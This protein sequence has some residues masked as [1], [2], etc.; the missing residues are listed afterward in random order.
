MKSRRISRRFLGIFCLAL[1]AALPLAR[2]WGYHQ[3]GPDRVLLMNNDTNAWCQVSYQGYNDTNT[4]NETYWVHSTEEPSS[5]TRYLKTGITHTMYRN[6]GTPLWHLKECR[7]GSGAVANA[8]RNYITCSKTAESINTPGLYGTSM[9]VADIGSVI[10][11]DTTESHIYSP[12]YEE[13]IG[14]VYFDAVNAQTTEPVVIGLEIATE[15][16]EGVSLNSS[17]YGQ[18]IWKPCPATFFTWKAGRSPVVTLIEENVTNMTLNITGGANALIYRIRAN[19]YEYLNGYRGPARFRIVRKEQATASGGDTAFVLV[20]NIVASY[21]PMTAKI[22]QYGT[23]D[24]TLT[25]ADVEGFV[26]SF[27]PALLSVSTT[28]IQMA[29]YFT[30]VTNSAEVVND[31]EE[32]FSLSNVR[33]ISRWRYLNQHIENWKTNEL[34]VSGSMAVSSPDLRLVSGVGDVEYYFAFEQNAP[35]YEPVD[36]TQP[37]RSGA[38]Y[39]RGWS[40]ELTNI[41]SRATYTAEDALPSG[42]TDWFTR[43]REGASDYAYISLVGEVTTNGAWGAN[44]HSVENN[45]R[46]KME[47]VSDHTWRYHYYIPTNAIGEHVRFHFEGVK[48]ATNDVPFVFNVTTNIWYANSTNVPYLPYTM[49]ASGSAEDAFDAEV[50]LDGSATHLQI[51]FND[52]KG[53]FAL[54]RG[55]YQNFNMWTDANDGYRGDYTS[56]TGVSDVK[57]RWD[58]AINDWSATK[59][60]NTLWREPFEVNEEDIGTGKDYEYYKLGAWKTPNGWSSE[61]SMYVPRYR[62]APYGLAL[63]L[64]GKGE[65]S[66]MLNTKDPAPNGIGTVDFAARVAQIPRFDGFC[67]DYFAGGMQNYA[68]SA[69]VTMSRLYDTQYNPLDISPANPSVSLIGYYQGTRNGCYEFR[70]TRSGDRQL[71]VALYRWKNEVANL[72]VENVITVVNSGTSLAPSTAQKALGVGGALN[73]APDSTSGATISGFNNLLVPMNNDDARLY[74]WTCMCLSLYSD[75]NGVHLNGYL[76]PNRNTSYLSADS[77]VKRVIAYRDEGSDLKKGGSPGIGSVGCQAG[78]ALV[79]T[80][81]FKDESTYMIRTKTDADKD[82]GQDS[83]YTDWDY[84]AENWKPYVLD[85]TTYDASGFTALI[86]TNQTVK[87]FYSKLGKEEGNWIDSGWETNITAFATNTFQFAPCV[88]PDYLVRL[89]TGPSDAE[90]VIDSVEVRSWR[91]S[92]TPNLSSKNGQYDAWAYTMASIETAADIEGAYDVQPAGTN[93]YAFI[94]NEP[95]VVSFTPKVDMVIDRALLVGGGGAGGWTLGGGGGGGGVLEY[96]WEDEPATVPAGTTIRITVGAGGDNFYKNNNDSGNWKA[97]GNGGL[98]RVDNIP[99]TGRGRLEAKGGGGD[100]GWNQRNAASGNATGGGA[101]QGNDNGYYSSRATGTSGQ[102]NSGGRAYGDRAGGGGGAD[103][104]EAGMGQDGNATDNKAGD[105]GA[106]RAS[107]ITGTVVYYGGGGGGGGGDG[108]KTPNSAQGGLGGIGGGGKGPPAKAALSDRNYMDGTDGL[109]GGG[110]GGSH[111]GAAG[112]NAGGRGGC[113]CVIL[114][115]RTAAKLC[116]LQPTKSYPADGPEYQNADYPMSIRSKWLDNGL[117]LFSFSYRDA[118]SNAVLRLQ[119]STNLVD[120]GVVYTRT[121]EPADSPNWTTLTNWSF[122]GVSPDKLKED[123][124]TYFLSLRAPH[125]GLMRL[126]MDPAVVTQALLQA[127]NRATRNLDF[128][129]ITVTRIFCYDEPELDARSWW[130]W[131]L[132]TEGWNGGGEPGRW[133]YLT[134]SPSGLSCSLNFSAL[135]ND[136][137]TTDPDTYGI[138]LGETG[139]GKEENYKKNN[140]F[141][142]SPEMTN[143]IASVSFRAR[144]FETNATKP[145]VVILYGSKDIGAYQAQPVDGQAWTRL[146][147]FVISNNT[148]QTYNWRT[149]DETWVREQVRSIRLEVGGARNGRNGPFEDWE[150]PAYEDRMPIQRVFLDEV[151]VSEPVGP[152]LKFFDVRPFRDEL[153]DM[154]PKAI[155]NINDRAEQPLLREAWGIQARVEPQQ[156]ADELDLKSLVVKMAAYVGTYPWG[157]ENWKSIPVGPNRFEAAL[158]C[159]DTTNL[160]FRST[161][162]NPASMISPVDLENGASYA[163][164]QYYVWVEYKSK[165]ATEEQEPTTHKLTES[166]WVMPEWYWPKDFN[167]EY[168]FGENFS[169]FTILDTVSPGRAWLNEVNYNNDDYNRDSY[170]FLEFMVPEGVDLTGWSIRLTDDTF[171]RGF[172]AEL[173]SMGQPIYSKEGRRYGIDS[174]NQFTVMTFVAP[175]GASLFSENESDGTWNKLQNAGMQL[176]DGSLKKGNMYELELVRPSGVVEHQ[177]V[178]SGTNMWAGSIFESK[179][180]ATNF[181]NDVKK[182]DF[183]SEVCFWAGEDRGGMATADKSLTLG[184]WR[185]HGEQLWD[186]G[187]TWTNDL[188]ATPGEL[189]LRNGQRQVIDQ[190]MLRPNG[191]YVWIDAIVNGTH[192]LQ[193]VDG[194]PDNATREK[195]TIMMTAGTTTNIRYKVDAW[196]EMA[197]CTTNDKPVVSTEVPGLARTFEI[198]LPSVSNNITVIANDRGDSRLFG[199]NYPWQVAE[200]DPYRPAILDWLLRKYPDKSPA[201]IAPAEQWDLAQTAFKGYLDLKAMYWLDIPPTAGHD[202]GGKRVSDWHLLFGYTKPFT[203]FSTEEDG[204]TYANNAIGA[205]KLLL[206]NK[207]DG[208]FHPP[209]TIQGLQPGSSSATDYASMSENW[210]S[211]TFKVTCA[212]NYPGQNTAYKPVKWFVFDEHSFDANGVAWIEVPDQSKKST[213][214]FNYGW[215][216]YFGTAG[217]LFNAKL[218]DAPSGLYSTEILRAVHTNSYNAIVSP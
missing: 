168:G 115:V 60:A 109:G 50:E 18:F 3:L 208:T 42:G 157:Y 171:K 46:T 195:R 214:G 27:S 178:V 132:H 23:Y 186:G 150:K 15:A 8:A 125:K 19:V 153:S 86:P 43:I 88:A 149:N 99:G 154:S 35:H 25:G 57:H 182:R 73:S 112:T 55:A 133:A 160:I 76:S 179:G 215:S 141:V 137:K 217:F 191:S 48:Y 14:T 167:R 107:D 26:G 54:S 32:S 20:D 53:A 193:Y 102:G 83:T 142:Q 79:R 5:R 199:T 62:I 89:Q 144:T 159:V 96:H 126:V 169:A 36:F 6:D 33:L 175:N 190:W 173:G 143:G 11:R 63:Q 38:Y 140:P 181:V 78:F 184:V 138:G 185:G 134:D 136:N 4:A 81:D 194:N 198:V 72:L 64:S 95:G 91:A 2:A 192:T 44:M 108:N 196:Y 106:G 201:D 218:D 22:N 148:Y 127:E 92:D 85:D 51:E 40:E 162:D 34:A 121:R 200:N 30:Y 74:R 12:Y 209:F 52:E 152:R 93:G 151:S 97:G 207:F 165:D 211:A 105:G 123:T 206:T 56:T 212:L 111:S 170:Q 164:V 189:N 135:V 29:A 37:A 155:T 77:S 9:P 130:G 158:T 61:N 114:R 128:G 39:G 119:I 161:Y 129:K 68:I 197:N 104:T 187:T 131:N 205:V 41:V 21:P 84:P 180:D 80:Y 116:V 203:P 139:E 69:K 147:E 65:G 24:G 7:A 216:Y 31:V 75:A 16:E 58:A 94:F 45:E 177:I 174:T 101:A 166:E 13:G 213:P 66:L 122:K 1:V 172:L 210:T 204:V 71:T 120:E 188:T 118:D 100:A 47:L 146:A 87:L 117:S 17:N 202:E 82:A 113:G 156:M 124:L 103:L 176:Q 67:Y 90:I 49:A 28:N 59:Y 70:V 183:A 163:V 98:T 10:M 110:A 145:S